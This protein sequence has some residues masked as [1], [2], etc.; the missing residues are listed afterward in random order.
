MISRCLT[1][2]AEA[3]E[4]G[5]SHPVKRNKPEPPENDDDKGLGEWIWECDG[6]WKRY[7]KKARTDKAT[8]IYVSSAF[9]C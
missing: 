2:R 9:F 1:T 5:I 4:Y 7:Q 3:R 6:N 8:D